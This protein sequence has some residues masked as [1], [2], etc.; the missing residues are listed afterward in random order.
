MRS[1]CLLAGLRRA[2]DQVDT[3]MKLA[4]LLPNLTVWLL[5]GS[6]LPW[7]TTSTG[8]TRLQSRCWRATKVGTCN[9]NIG[10]HVPGV[11]GRSRGV[12]K[13][14]AL[15]TKLR[16]AASNRGL[17]PLPCSACPGLTAMF[18]ACPAATVDEEDAGGASSA[19]GADEKYEHSEMLLYKA[20]VLEEG[21][22][23][24]RCCCVNGQ[25]LLGGQLNPCACGQAG[26]QVGGEPSHVG[27]PPHGRQNTCCI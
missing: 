4:T 8:T 27:H 3:L 6:R 18:L 1:G 23:E 13:P 15:C 10:L 25:G 26:G 9:C 19:G 22:L 17:P 5:Q 14:S 16:K 24:P 20:M 11:C 2:W 21:E 7:H 12:C